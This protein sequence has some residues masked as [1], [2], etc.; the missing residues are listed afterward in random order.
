LW[1]GKNIVIDGHTRLIAAKNIGMNDIPV[2]LTDFK[3]EEEALEYA[4]H[5]QR[6]RRNMSDADLLSR[7]TTISKITLVQKRILESKS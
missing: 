4:I 3:D 6:D 1:K 5:N 7:I 2:A